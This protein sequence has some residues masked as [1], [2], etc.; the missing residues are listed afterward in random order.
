MAGTPA[1]PAPVVQLTVVRGKPPGKTITVTGPRFTIGRDEAC[2]LRPHSER[3]SR[4]H[5]ELII[6]PQTVLIRD[7]CSRN[8]T[9]VNRRE[10]AATARIRDGDRLQI[11][12]LVFAVSIRGGRG[13]GAARVPSDDLVASWLIADEEGEL[14]GQLADVY[15]GDTRADG[16]QDGT[17]AGDEVATDRVY[18]LLRE[19]RAPELLGS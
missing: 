11:G 9:F 4:R 3:V 6:T 1:A 17:A 8:G 13:A 7:L 12:P 14:P 15:S 10:V 18:E 19:V 16:G 5:A 2:Q